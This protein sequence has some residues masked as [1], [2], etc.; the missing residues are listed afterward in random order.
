M[1]KKKD[2]SLIPNGFYEAIGELSPKAI[3]TYLA[4][5]R[6]YNHKTKLCYPSALAI[7]KLVNLSERRVSDAIRELI[8]K[9]CITKKS[10]GYK[11]KNNVYF[12]NSTHV[13][14]VQERDILSTEQSVNVY[15]TEVTKS[16]EQA[17]QNKYTNEYTINKEKQGST[18]S[19]HNVRDGKTYTHWE[20]GELIRLFEEAK[21]APIITPL[22]SVSL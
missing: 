21:S 14:S 6:F 22:T 20:I 2:F 1:E 12:L 18:I 19:I 3:K 13:Q 7:S 16:P 8:E 9:G 5:C 15:G 10:H 17:V 4:I 11:G